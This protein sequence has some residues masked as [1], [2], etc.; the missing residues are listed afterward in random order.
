MCIWEEKGRDNGLEEVW[1][2]NK[3]E[4]ENRRGEKKG[5]KMGGGIGLILSD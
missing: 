5:E 2:E 3:G 1:G 4:V